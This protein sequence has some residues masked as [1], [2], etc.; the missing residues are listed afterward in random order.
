MLPEINSNAAA[1][2]TSAVSRVHLAAG[3]VQDAAG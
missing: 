2:R 1:A 3:L